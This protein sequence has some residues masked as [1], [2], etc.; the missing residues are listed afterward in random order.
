MRARKPEA[1]AERRDHL[2]QTARAMLDEGVGLPEL[3]LNELARRADMTKSN[4][5]RYFES[6]EAVLLA[7]LV[8]EWT[9][10]L[11]ALRAEEPASTHVDDLMRALARSLVARP[12][13][14]LLTSVL[15]SVLELNLS[16]G[17]IRAFKLLTLAFFTE[18]AELLTRRAPALSLE[19]ALRLL[20]DLIAL[21]VGLYPITHPPDAVKR[22]MDHPLL[23][24]RTPDFAAEL[25]RMLVALGRDAAPDARP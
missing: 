18:L 12:R 2:L 6:R 24:G 16:E 5:Y 14:C 17:A 1:K 8:E 23:C 21:I 20:G 19:G 11:G 10:W 15:P 9:T 22:A 25:E 7:L 13:L 3:S 4:V